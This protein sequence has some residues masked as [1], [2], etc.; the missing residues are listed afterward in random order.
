MCGARVERDPSEI[1]S[2]APQIASQPSLSTSAVV[3]DQ[4]LQSEPS[5]QDSTDAEPASN[6]LAELSLFELNETANHSN[7]ESIGPGTSESSASH[8]ETESVSSH[9]RSYPGWDE[10]L[11]SWAGGNHQYRA[12]AKHRGGLPN[13]EVGNTANMWGIVINGQGIALGRAL[14][15]GGFAA[16]TNMPTAGMTLAYTEPW[17]RVRHVLVESTGTERV[18]KGAL[19]TFGLLGLGAKVP[20][21]AVTIGFGTH[22]A[23][24]EADGSEFAWKTGLTPLTRSSREIADKVRIGPPTSYSPASTRPQGT[25]DSEDVLSQIRQLGSLLEQGLITRHEFETKKQLL[26]DRL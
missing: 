23:I 26:L 7:S 12:R 16:V 18:N 13:E 8:V 20:L 3:S 6:G 1:T 10:W 17:K 22:D 19:A 24:F 11:G 25:S 9:S 2:P 15:G 14:F 4:P 21:V 5:E